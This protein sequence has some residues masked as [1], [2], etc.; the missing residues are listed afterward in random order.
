M[1]ILPP[2]WGKNLGRLHVSCW[3]KYKYWWPALKA[4][5]A[6]GSLIPSLQHHTP[7]CIYM[8]FSSADCARHGPECWMFPVHSPASHHQLFTPAMVSLS[9]CTHC[10]HWW[11]GRV[12]M[13]LRPLDIPWFTGLHIVF[14]WSSQ[15]ALGTASKGEVMAKKV[16][17][18]HPEGP[19]KKEWLVSYCFKNNGFNQPLSKSNPIILQKKWKQETVNGF[20]HVSKT[21]FCKMNL[22]QESF[23]PHT[24][25]GLY[26]GRY[27]SEG[28][29]SSFLT[30]SYLLQKR[31]YYAFTTI[32]SL[33]C[34][35]WWFS[36]LVSWSLLSE[37]NTF[38]T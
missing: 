32:N 28:S 5:W 13:P 37:L 3:V 12:I 34:C 27:L 18:P 21:R 26:K 9:F 1:L 20:A 16:C 7:T 4:S 24:S 25:S 2:P 36:S 23:T 31:E 17:H 14:C 8:T 6:R 30:H 38:N 35:S 19:T 29:F 10:A 33:P 22:L 11:L 15:W